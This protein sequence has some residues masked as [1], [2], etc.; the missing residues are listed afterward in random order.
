M[1]RLATEL[2]GVIVEPGWK[3]EA[4]GKRIGY[5]SYTRATAC[6]VEGPNRR[7]LGVRSLGPAPDTIKNIADKGKQGKSAL[8]LRKADIGKD[9]NRLAD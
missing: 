3:V 1:E 7:G 9:L 5:D 6:A 2:P 4:C 8:R